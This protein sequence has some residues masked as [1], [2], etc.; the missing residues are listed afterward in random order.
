MGQVLHGGDTSASFAFTKGVKQGCFLAP[1]L[2]NLLF[3]CML[4][5]A[6]KDSEEGVYI[7]YRFDGYLFDLRRLNVKTRCLQELI[8]ESL[9]TDDWAQPVTVR[10]T[11]R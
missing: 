6:V 7:R 3:A 1:I 10:E 2:F 4:F 11:Y 5:Q 8:H 9:Y